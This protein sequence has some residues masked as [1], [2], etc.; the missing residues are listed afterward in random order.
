MRAAVV[1][2]VACAVA[3]VACDQG[4]GSSE[5]DRADAADAAGPDVPEHSHPVGSHAPAIYGKPFECPAAA[6]RFVAI[7]EGLL[8]WMCLTTENVRHGP[9]VQV[10]ADGSRSNVGWWRLGSKTRLW[11]HWDEAGK[12]TIQ[13]RYVS[14]QRHGVW[15]QK[16]HGELEYFCVEYGDLRWSTTDE[17]VA[18]SKDCP[19]E[20]PPALQG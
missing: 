13:G 6:S 16:P 5:S 14:G 8:T 19:L 18:R 7:D 2:A 3:T 12:V 11:T 9:Y 15:V 17:D 10:R 20:L 4:G 1:A